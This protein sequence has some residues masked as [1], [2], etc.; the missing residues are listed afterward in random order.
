MHSKEISL[1]L[2][3]KDHCI[4]DAQEKMKASKSDFSAEENI[5]AHNFK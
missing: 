4:H 5:Y 3:D 2:E 1:P